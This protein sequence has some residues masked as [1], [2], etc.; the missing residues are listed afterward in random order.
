MLTIGATARNG[1]QLTKDS[2]FELQLDTVRD[3]FEQ[4][5]HGI[6]ADIFDDDDGDIQDQN[7]DVDNQQLVQN[8]LWTTS[9]SETEQF[10]RFPDVDAG[11]DQFLHAEPDQLNTLH[12][13][14]CVGPGT[15]RMRDGPVQKDRRRDLE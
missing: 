8:S 7:D 11:N 9:R 15:P 2:I 10:H 14:V 6:I 3:G 12:D 13:I 1:D 5:L 4:N